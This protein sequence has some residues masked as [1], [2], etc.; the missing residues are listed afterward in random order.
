MTSCVPMARAHATTDRPAAPRPPGV[1][2]GSGLGAPREGLERER[3]EKAQARF[4]RL[5]GAGHGPDL[6]GM[7]RPHRGE[8]ERQSD[9]GVAELCATPW[10][11]QGAAHEAEKPPGGGAAWVST[12]TAWSLQT[13][14]PPTA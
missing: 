7:Q 11:P 14:V 6:P 10:A 3:I 12:F 13:A 8:G 1:R 9:G 2:R 5:H 4:G